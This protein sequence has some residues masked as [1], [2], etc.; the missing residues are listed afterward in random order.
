MRGNN[1]HPIYE[2]V[3]IKKRE[4]ILSVTEVLPHTYPTNKYFTPKHDAI[5]VGLKSGSFRDKNKSKNAFYGL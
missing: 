3:K 4:N 5:L 2:I 1:K